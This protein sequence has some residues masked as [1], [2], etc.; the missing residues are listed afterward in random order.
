MERKIIILGDI[1]KLK[2]SE[3]WYKIPEYNNQKEL[4]WSNRW[5]QGFQ[6]KY[7]IK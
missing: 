1:I 4:A 7:G 2:A 3:F 5:L 6:I